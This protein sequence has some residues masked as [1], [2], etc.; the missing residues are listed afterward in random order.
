M[1]IN[2]G[3]NFIGSYFCKGNITPVIQNRNIIL[4]KCY[5]GSIMTTNDIS[6]EEKLIKKCFSKDSIVNFI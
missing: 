3:S 2:K 1:I 4:K 5:L 6:E